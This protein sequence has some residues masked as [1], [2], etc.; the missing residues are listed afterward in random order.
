MPQNEKKNK[1]VNTF[2]TLPNTQ[3]KQTTKPLKH[4][5]AKKKQT[6]KNKQTPHKFLSAPKSRVA[7]R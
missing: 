6:K 2:A 7:V 5:N 3:K 1:H 4:P